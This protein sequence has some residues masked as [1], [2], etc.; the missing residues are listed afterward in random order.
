MIRNACDPASSASIAVERSSAESFM[1][2]STLS[3]LMLVCRIT[4]SL[5]F[6]ISAKKTTHDIY[7]TYQPLA[8]FCFVI[9]IEQSLIVFIKSM[10]RSC[11]TLI[12]ENAND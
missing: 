12:T 2:R 1:V 11:I 5:A 4:T 10:S 8:L 6:F 7:Y 9:I 3:P